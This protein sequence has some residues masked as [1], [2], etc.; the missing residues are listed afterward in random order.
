[1]LGQSPQEQISFHMKNQKQKT[2]SVVC[3]QGIGGHMA[4]AFN[5]PPAEKVT[6]GAST[7]H[8]YFSPESYKSYD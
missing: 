3:T 4:N 6:D 8:H 5:S 2:Q 7:Q 1:M